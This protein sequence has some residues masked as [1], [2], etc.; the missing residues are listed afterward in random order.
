M[1]C[2]S[3]V[4]MKSRAIFRGL[5]SLLLGAA[6]VTPVAAHHAVGRPT[7]AVADEGGIATI[8]IALHIGAYAVQC[9]ASPAFPQPA[10]AAE[11]LLQI[12]RADDGQPYTG[13]VRFYLHGDGWFA[14]PARLVGERSGAQGRYRQTLVFGSQGGYIVSANFS[15]EGRPYSIEFPIQ[16]GPARSYFT[17]LVAIAT[18][19]G[20]LLLLRVV[21]WRRK[22]ARSRTGS[23][24]R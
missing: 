1:P 24:S 11:V 5:S 7:Y 16:V 2:Y 22:G 21:A 19:A 8:Q 3:D 15:S 14:D 17:L 4:L 6:L 12:K 13:V 23:G 20:L 9:V 18:L 10:Q